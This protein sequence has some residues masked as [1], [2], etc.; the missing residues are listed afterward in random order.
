M[1]NEL[2]EFQEKRDKLDGR[3]HPFPFWSDLKFEVSNPLTTILGSAEL[4]RLKE[5]NISPEN[6]KYIRNIEKGADRI[7]KVL[8]DFLDSAPSPQDRNSG[9]LQRIPATT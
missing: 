1:K 6:D 5:G 7:Q 3:T 8:E 4:L 2:K 9:K